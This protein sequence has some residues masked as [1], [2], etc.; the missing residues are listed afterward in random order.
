MPIILMSVGLIIPLIC[1][2]LKSDMIS[3]IEKNKLKWACRRG[4]LELDLVLSEFLETKLESLSANQKKSFEK[5]LLCT[6]PELE[7]WLLKKQPLLQSELELFEIIELI[8][9]VI[10]S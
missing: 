10:K 8:K 4:M 1:K 5:L 6:D 9:T 3:T 7:N 2:E